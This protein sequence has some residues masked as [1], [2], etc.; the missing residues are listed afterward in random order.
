MAWQDVLLIVC[1]F[2]AA[3]FFLYRTIKK[4]RWCP[5]IY[6]DGSCMIDKS[7]DYKETDSKG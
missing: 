1:L 2:I 6:G 7:D 4:K 3:A 5:D